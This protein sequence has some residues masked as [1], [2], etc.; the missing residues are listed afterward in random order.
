MTAYRTI[1]GGR[2]FQR[3]AAVALA[4]AV[5]ACG[6]ASR[7][8]AENQS[9]AVAITA[10]EKT[11][12]TSLEDLSYK[13]SNKWD[14]CVSSR[15]VFFNEAS[16]AIEKINPLVSKMGD[17]AP[18]VVDIALL[19]APP[20]GEN[21]VG[22]FLCDG[23]SSNANALFRTVSISNEFLGKLKEASLA[24]G[25]DGRTFPSALAFVIYHEVGHAVL[26]HSAV[27]LRP[28]SS[29]GLPQEL[30]ADQFALDMMFGAG[31]DTR[32]VEIARAAREAF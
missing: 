25:G 2:F 16:V 7:F 27:K 24:N 3:L 18:P 10:A 4:L 19:D 21:S 31:I 6:D 23:M 12:L 32:G 11:A 17:V 22:V 13:N 8:S 30:E 28:D 26:N 29:F 15:S 14:N 5:S 20:R 9:A 1:I